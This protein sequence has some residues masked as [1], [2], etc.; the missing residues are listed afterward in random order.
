MDTVPM[1]G[2]EST[3]FTDSESGLCSSLHPDTPSLPCRGPGSCRSA[4]GTCCSLGQDLTPAFQQCPS[5][6]PCQLEQESRS[7]GS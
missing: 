6:V 4:T 3:W 1:S 5:F 2:Q 7:E